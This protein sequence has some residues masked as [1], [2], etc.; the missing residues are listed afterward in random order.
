[1]D[2]LFWTLMAGSVIWLGLLLFFYMEINN[3]KQITT[4]SRMLNR[5]TR[6][7]AKMVVQQ[8]RKD[9]TTDVGLPR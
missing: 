1:M 4:R 5:G 9:A 7:S 6:S 2:V 8:R 3:D